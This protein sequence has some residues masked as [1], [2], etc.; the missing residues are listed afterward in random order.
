MPIPLTLIQFAPTSLL[1]GALP[2]PA[3]LNLGFERE[4]QE[5]PDQHDSSKQTDALK[6]EWGGNRGDNICSYQQLKPK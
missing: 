1:C 4:T 2:W 5:G 6:R 3:A